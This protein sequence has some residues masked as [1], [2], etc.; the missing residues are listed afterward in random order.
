MRKLASIRTIEAVHPI[1]GADKIEMVIID[2]WQVVSQK[3]NFKEGDKCVY[4]EIDSIFKTNSPVGLS[5]PADK[6]STYNTE[7]EGRVDGFRIKTIRLRGQISQGYALPLGY[8]SSFK[9]VNLESEDLTFELEVLKYDKP[10]SGVGGPGRT[11][12]AGSF[13]TDFIRKTDQERAQNLKRQIFDRYEDG[14]TFEVSYKLDGSST[15][16]GRYEKAGEVVDTIC[17][18]NL[19]LKLDGPP[20][21]SQFLIVGLPILNTFVEKDILNIAVQGELVSPNI[22]KNFEK[23]TT[24]TFYAYSFWSVK[25]AAYLNPTEARELAVKL[26]IKYVPVMH[27]NVTLQEL[28]GEGLD[29]NSL[30][31][32]LLEYAEGPSGLNGKY[33]EGLVYKSQDG[34]FSFKTISNSYLLKEK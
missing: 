13:P 12:A 22:Q 26:G 18:R 8:F 4:F 28:F 7:E 14:T 20:D 17:S 29:Q 6:A 27:E 1:E 9:S 19:A 3:G 15:T 31:T 5:L 33:R 25:D 16:V 24:P 21:S 30:L 2:G 32:K 34:S 23:V 11:N 10:E